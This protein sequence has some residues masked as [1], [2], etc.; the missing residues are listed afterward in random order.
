LSLTVSKFKEEFNGLDR[1][2]VPWLEEI[3]VLHL[4]RQFSGRSGRG[5]GKEV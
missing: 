2:S 1:S 4:D 3:Y 5:E